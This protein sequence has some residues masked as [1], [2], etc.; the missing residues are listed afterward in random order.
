[1]GVRE[2]FLFSPNCL[3]F[4]SVI[5]EELALVAE[6]VGRQH[7]FRFDCHQ[8]SVVFGKKLGAAAIGKQRGCNNRRSS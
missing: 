2:Q 3:S 6:Q 1:M 5:G 4:I 7:L 8:A